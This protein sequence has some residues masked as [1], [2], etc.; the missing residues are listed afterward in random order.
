M[1]FKK[2]KNINEKI[3]RQKRAK[4]WGAVASAVAAAAGTFAAQSMDFYNP[5]IFGISTGIAAY[6]VISSINERL[7]LKYSREQE[8][9]A[10]AVATELL[11]YRGI[12]E[13]ALASALRK[14]KHHC[15]YTGNFMALSAE[16]S[17][18]SLDQRISKIGNP[19][20]QTHPGFFRKTSFVNTMNAMIAFNAH[21]YEYSRKLVKR[22]I[23][24]EVAG[25]DDY[26]LLAMT[27]LRMHDTEKKNEQALQW[28]QKAKELEAESN[29][30][31]PK[32]QAI[33]LIRLGENQKAKEN[34]KEY[35]ALLK[36]EE[37]TIETD[38]KAFDTSMRLRYINQEKK[39]TNNL[40]TKVHLM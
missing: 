6:S 22:N 36:A 10:D 9:K 16:G 3:K 20:A 12:S 40:L 30:N 19:S 23:E 26:I 1:K 29:L 24:A 34:L 21:Q 18:P 32:Q 33:T 28:L 15:H 4:F 35:L 17:H 8:F 11:K 7:G 38:E 2:Q 37:E 14:V 39:W 13:R 27:N 5:G 31:L 25:T